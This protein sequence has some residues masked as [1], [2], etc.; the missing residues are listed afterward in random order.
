VPP[1]NK[2]KGW[3]RTPTF[4]LL[5]NP[6]KASLANVVSAVMALDTLLSFL[7]PPPV[8]AK[9]EVVRV[10]PDGQNKRDGREREPR[11]PQ[12]AHGHPIPNA[13]GQ[14]TGK[15]IDTTA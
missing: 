9:P 15:L 12:E 11:K 1:T 13:Q 7:Q 14:I 4:L 10:N 3:R 5:W 6:A 2:T 8:H